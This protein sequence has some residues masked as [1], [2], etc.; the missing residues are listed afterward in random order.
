MR[1]ACTRLGLPRLPLVQLHWDDFASPGYV[2]V[3]AA[4]ADLQRRGLVGAWGV[5]NWDVPRLLQLI[6]AGLT[7]ATNQV[8]GVGA[9]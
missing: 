7:P 1:A 6:D 5:C 8:K 4:L 9:V 2:A 3:A